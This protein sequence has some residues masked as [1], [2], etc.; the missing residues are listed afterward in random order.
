MNYVSHF[1]DFI[2]TIS[3]FRW[4]FSDRSRVDMEKSDRVLQPLFLRD[5]TPGHHRRARGTNSRRR[6]P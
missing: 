3:E 6:R 2:I 4:S 5:L 1:T